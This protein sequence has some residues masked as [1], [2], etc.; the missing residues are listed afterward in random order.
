MN[1]LNPSFMESI[2]SAK[3]NARVRPNDI[4]VKAQK[5]AF[6]GD[7]S[8]ATLGSKIWNAS[9]QKIKTENFYIKFKEYIATWFGRKCKCNVC[10]F[11]NS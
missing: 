11:N 3:L 4:I 1:D 6:F 9:P 10:S 2:F 8:L 5:S 7:K